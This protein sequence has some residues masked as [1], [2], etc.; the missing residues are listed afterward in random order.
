M[1]MFISHVKWQTCND[2]I[3]NC[4]QMV[5]RFWNVQKKCGG[6]KEYH[7]QSKF[8][9]SNF[10]LH[11]LQFTFKFY[12]Y[13][14]NYKWN[15][16]WPY[17]KSV[18]QKILT[19]PLFMKLF[20]LYTI[21]LKGRKFSYVQLFWARDVSSLMDYLPVRDAYVEHSCARDE[22]DNKYLY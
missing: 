21:N 6:F 5:S 18:H 1:L 19:L 17:Y 16:A 12:L 8:A 13:N 14:C 11:N 15:T 2:C 22:C 4:S 20:A 10:N 9:I 3:F 7:R